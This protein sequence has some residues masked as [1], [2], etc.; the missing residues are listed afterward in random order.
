MSLSTEVRDLLDDIYL[1]TSG[2]GGAFSGP[3]ELYR[4]ARVKKPDIKRSTITQY[5][6]AVKG[7]TLHSRI[8]RVFPTRKYLALYPGETWIGDIIYLRS[9]R[10]ISSQKVANT[11]NYALII[12]DLFTLKIY[13][14]IMPRKTAPCTLEAFKVILA[15]SKVTPL[16]LQ[17]D[18]GREFS[19]AF[20]L[21]CKAHSIQIYHSTTKLKASRVEVGN[22]AIK[23]LLHRIMTHFNSTD[24]GKYLKLAISIYNANGSQGL[25]NSLSPDQAEQPNHIPK[26]QKFYLKRRAEYASKIEKRRPQARYQIGDTV[27][28]VNSEVLGG[29]RGYEI[30]FSQK[31]YTIT[32]ITK[33]TPRM[34]FI[35]VVKGGQPRAFYAEE[36][37]L[38]KEGVTDH[39]KIL[40]IA[41]SKLQALSVLRN[42]KKKKSE[43]VYLCILENEG[44]P[45][46]LTEDQI[47]EYK[48]GVP[49]MEAYWQSHGS[50]D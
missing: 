13:G 29:Q 30:R 35:G 48:N 41:S 43:R 17:V 3:A 44:K 2:G 49:K 47:K 25:P 20:S 38:A 24:V 18:R 8:L 7:Y 50:A 4:R 15:R 16:K 37:R 9:L 39:P 32:A 6:Q 23:L 45:K 27:R 40:D 36:L 42:G 19:G 1:A 11:A 5:L 31:L 26:I 10:L 34:Y 22:Y 33:T 21:Y 12:I 46:Y 14:E 28:K